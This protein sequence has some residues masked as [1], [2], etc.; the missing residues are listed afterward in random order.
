MHNLKFKTRTYYFIIYYNLGKSIP[1]WVAGE[2]PKYLLRHEKYTLTCTL[3]G[4][5]GVA[6]ISLWFIEG[7]LYNQ[8]LMTDVH[9]Q[10]NCFS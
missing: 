10:S 9:Y 8:F 1:Y 2:C 4:N 6:I 7:K 5:E 3:N